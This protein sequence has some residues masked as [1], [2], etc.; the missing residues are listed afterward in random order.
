[1]AEKLVVVLTRRP[2][3]ADDPAAEVLAPAGAR[4]VG[5][6]MDDPEFERLAPEADGFVFSGGFSRAML[7]KA[8]RCRIIARDGLGYDNVDVTAATERGVWVTIIPDALV[9]D[10]ADHTMML[11]L[12]L[13]RRLLE[14]DRATRAG[15]WRP[16]Q[17]A[18]YSNPPRK[19]R[20]AVLGLIGLGRI[21]RAVA[22]RARGFGA[23]V[24]AADPVVS[25]EVAA[26][27]GATLLPLD[28]LLATADFVSI[29]VPLS[30]STRC[31]IGERELRLMRPSALFLNTSRG[32]VCDE[33]ALIRALEAGWI[34]GAGLDVFEVEPVG[35]DNPLLKMRN[36][37]L[38]PHTASVSDVSNRE[39]RAEAAREV[40]RVLSGGRPREA[41]VVNREL[42]GR[43]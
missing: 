20:G 32:A 23:K 30:A 4:V 24:V 28:E 5:C 16:A 8:P 27:V 10:V 19:L 15:E 6:W 12:A 17:M 21:G 18:L 43:Q 26:S 22:E 3:A 40:L 13:D 11:L 42:F 1:V 2:L 33:G 37:V 39:R 41:A 25:A 29:H 14:L 31:L 36:V 7:E 38:T 34:R 9:D 35:L